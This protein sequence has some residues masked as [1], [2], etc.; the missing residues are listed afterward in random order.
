MKKTQRQ[1]ELELALTTARRQRKRLAAQNSQ[2]RFDLRRITANYVDL[3][4][5]LERINGVLPERHKKHPR[6]RYLR[7][8]RSVDAGSDVQPA[9]GGQAPG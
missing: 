1:L 4:A 3:R 6:A 5:Y 2:L 8:D 7:R 9:R